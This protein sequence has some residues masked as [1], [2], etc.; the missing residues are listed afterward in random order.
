MCLFIDGPRAFSLQ[1]VNVTVFE[2]QT[3]NQLY[4]G[5]ILTNMMCAGADAGGRD[6]CQ[7]N[8]CLFVLLIFLSSDKY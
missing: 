1:E 4:R 8:S 2:P 7:V 5:K 6:A 3:C